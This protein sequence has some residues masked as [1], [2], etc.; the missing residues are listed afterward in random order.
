MLSLKSSQLLELVKI[1]DCDQ[2]HTIQAQANRA[3][4]KTIVL[5]RVLTKPLNDNIRKRYHDVFERLGQLQGEYTIQVDKS[6]RPVVHPP[7]KVPAP[8]GEAIRAELD[9]LTAE[10]IIVPVTEPT[11]WV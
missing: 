9:R 7:R 1:V 6:V 2:I 3:R 5:N 11:K 10:N 8:M 4:D